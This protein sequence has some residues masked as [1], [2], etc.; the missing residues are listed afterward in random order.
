[1]YKRASFSKNS[2]SKT[3]LLTRLVVTTRSVLFLLSQARTCV[4]LCVCVCRF[5]NVVRARTRFGRDKAVLLLLS[6]SLCLQVVIFRDVL[7][8][9]FGVL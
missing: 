4:R 5:K 3:S 2:G 9:A 6:L 7:D 1:M 8:P